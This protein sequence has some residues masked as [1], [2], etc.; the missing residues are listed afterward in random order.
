M[1]RVG[2]RPFSFA[3]HLIPSIV[4][5]VRWELKVGVQV[6][7]VYLATVRQMKTIK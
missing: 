4:A 5:L 3:S 7:V 1:Y 2:M 6:K